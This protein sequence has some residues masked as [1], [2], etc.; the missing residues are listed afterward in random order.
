MKWV[1]AIF[2]MVCAALACADMYRGGKPRGIRFPDMKI[3]ICQNDRHVFE[4]T[5]DAALFC[6]HFATLDY[7]D[8]ILNYAEHRQ[9]AV[10]VAKTVVDFLGSTND[11]RVVHWEQPEPASTNIADQIIARLKGR[12]VTD[13]V[14]PIGNGAAQ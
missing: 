5:E 10:A 13:E 2:C 1:L 4:V 8:C 9:L 3:R 12:W 11:I 6:G 7:P 14:I